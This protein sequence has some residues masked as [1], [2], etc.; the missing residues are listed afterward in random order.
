[1]KLFVESQLVK[2]EQVFCQEDDDETEDINLDDDGDEDLIQ[3]MVRQVHL[4]DQS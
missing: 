4:R 3:A 2:M 1:M